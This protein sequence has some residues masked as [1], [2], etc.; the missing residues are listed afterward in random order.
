MTIGTTTTDD[1]ATTTIWSDCSHTVTGSTG[2]GRANHR[3]DLC[4]PG[5]AAGGDAAAQIS[6]VL[7]N[8]PKTPFF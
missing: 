5:G 4:C 8:L 7:A 6:G 3:W 2:F 1:N